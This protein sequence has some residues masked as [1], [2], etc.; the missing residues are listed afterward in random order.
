VAYGKTLGQIMF[1]GNVEMTGILKNA[2]VTEAAFDRDVLALCF[3]AK[4]YSI[5]EGTS[6]K[7][8]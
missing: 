8:P 2:A 6:M 7:N 4:V 3:L 1:G 5:I